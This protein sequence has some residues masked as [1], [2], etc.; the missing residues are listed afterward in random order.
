[1]IFHKNDN[2]RMKS[3]LPTLAQPLLVTAA[4]IDDAILQFQ[5]MSA[6]P[7]PRMH[8]LHKLQEWLRRTELGAIYLT[9]RDRDVWKTGRDLMSLGKQPIKNQLTTLL[10]DFFLPL[11]HRLFRRHQ[12]RASVEKNCI[13][14]QDILNLKRRKKAGTTISNLAPTSPS[15]PT[16]ALLEWPT[17]LAQCLPQSCL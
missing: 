4:A 11:Y 9:G 1:M 8:E 5:Q 10:V 7:N 2:A 15:T 14:K 12:V 3:V 6:I 13:S 17:S 16:V